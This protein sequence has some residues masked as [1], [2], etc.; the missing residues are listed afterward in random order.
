MDKSNLPPADQNL[1]EQMIESLKLKHVVEG[2]EFIEVSH[3]KMIIDQ[4]KRDLLRELIE[5]IYKMGSGTSRGNEV[6]SK[7]A[8]INFLN[9][10]L[11]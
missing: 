11:K 2:W 7:Q 8:T 10:K 5:D 6:L 1:A 4:A 3:A 9:S